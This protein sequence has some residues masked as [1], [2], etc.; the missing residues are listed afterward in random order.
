[1][2][3]HRPTVKCVA[4]NAYVP[5]LVFSLLYAFVVA[6]SATLN[7]CLVSS[8]PHTGT[9]TNTDTSSSSSTDSGGRRHR[10]GRTKSK[11]SNHSASIRY[12][13]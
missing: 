13:G 8:F 12:E 5:Y 2:L 9:D 7:L 1:M 10:G 4:M 11:S 6:S 3:G